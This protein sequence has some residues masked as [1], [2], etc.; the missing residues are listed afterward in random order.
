MNFA[1]VIQNLSWLAIIVAALLVAG[2]LF[3]FQDIATFFVP[4]D[5]FN[6]YIATTTRKSVPIC[7]CNALGYEIPMKKL[8]V[9]FR[10]DLTH[11]LKGGKN[12]TNEYV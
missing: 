7:D 10:Y 1:E 8:K 2:F 3:N 5:K 9:N 12:D 4:I 6:S 11:L